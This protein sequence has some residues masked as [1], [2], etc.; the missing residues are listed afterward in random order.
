[1]ASEGQTSSGDAG[2]SA[3]GGAGVAVQ[4]SAG[5]RLSGTRTD[6]GPA[7]FCVGG[8]AGS[9]WEPEC[10]QHPRGGQLS[11]HP[12]AG[13][14]AAHQDHP[15]HRH[16]ASAGDRLRD[17]VRRQDVFGRGADR[18][19]LG[20][21]KGQRRHDEPRQRGRAAPWR[22][23]HPDRCNGNG[24]QRR[25]QGGAGSGAGER[26]GGGLY[27]KRRAA[28]NEP[29]AHLGRVCGPVAGRNV[30]AGLLGRGRHVDLCG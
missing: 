22:P 26:C 8:A 20:C 18:R 13:R 19:L 1:M 15:H 29:D 21:G 11:D 16:G 3:A 23:G 4:P 25:G 14:L 7:A 28:A 17:A 5:P 9:P 27:P 30:G 12:L 2:A 6:A 24:G 10:C